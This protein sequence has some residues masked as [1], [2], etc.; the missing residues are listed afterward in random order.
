MSGALLW[1]QD[2]WGYVLAAMI[3]LKGTLYRMVLLI[4]GVISYIRVGIWDMF[5][6]LY[7]LL[8][9]MCMFFLG[10]LLKNMGSNALDEA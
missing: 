10:L 3:M 4:G 8:W 6:P 2:P 7:V 1:K 5:I 9:F